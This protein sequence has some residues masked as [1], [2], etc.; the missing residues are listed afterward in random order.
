LLRSLGA[1]HGNMSI[2]YWNS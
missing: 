2:I 1:F